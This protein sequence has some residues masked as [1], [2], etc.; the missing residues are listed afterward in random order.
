MKH[1][2]KVS[3]II[4]TKNESQG[5]ESVLKSVRKYV[6][7]IIVVD[8]HSKDGAGKISKKMRAKF[9]LDHGLGKGN[10]V[11]TGIKK[12]TGDI[13][14]IF[15]ADGSPNAKDIPRLVKTLISSEADMVITSRRTG[16]SF[17]FDINL[18]GM[19]RT[20]GSD[21]MTFL[22]NKRFGTNFSDILYNFR[23][24]KSSSLK[25]INPS[26]NGFDIEQEMLVCALKHRLLVIEIPSREEKRKWGKSKLSTLS[27]IGLLCKLIAQLVSR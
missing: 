1:K 13:I 16:G 25:K 27:G 20:L 5:L 22:V 21:F 19:I 24:F 6:N 15:D 2:H 10:A 12:A 26:A 7:E 17:D 4:P 3:I 23:A 14:I 11:R 9:Y 18:N 8:G